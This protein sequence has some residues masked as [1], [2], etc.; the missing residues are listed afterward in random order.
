MWCFVGPRARGGRGRNSRTVQHDKPVSA[1]THSRTHAVQPHGV[2][3]HG[4]QPQ[5]SSRP[6][7]CRRRARTFRCSRSA[8][9]PSGIRTLTHR[10]SL[11]L[12]ASCGSSTWP[13]TRRVRRTSTHFITSRAAESGSAPTRE[14]TRLCRPGSPILAPSRVK[15]LGIEPDWYAGQ[16]LIYF[17]LLAGPQAGRDPILSRRGDHPARATWQRPSARTDDRALRV[18]GYRHRVRVVDPKRPYARACNHR[19]G[20]WGNDCGRHVDEVVVEQCGRPRGPQH[21]LIALG[22]E[23]AHRRTGRPIHPHRRVPCCRSEPVGRF[24]RIATRRPTPMP[25]LQQSLKNEYPSASCA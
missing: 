17:E 6:L 14:L 5:R 9:A 3:P 18:L 12:D 24:Q 16:P 23:T 10:R 11:K 20:G 4:V 7:G 2:Q 21:S 15:I 1:L 19:R 25:Q 8:P 13:R 22:R